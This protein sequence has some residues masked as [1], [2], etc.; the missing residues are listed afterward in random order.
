MKQD[1]V[2]VSTTKFL[3]RNIAKIISMGEIQA[4]RT[5]SKDR[6]TFWYVVAAQTKV[7]LSYKHPSHL[8]QD[9]NI[10]FPFW[11]LHSARKIRTQAT[12]IS[13]ITLRHLYGNWSSSKVERALRIWNC[14]CSD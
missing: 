9:A 4:K 2:L 10:I 12:V 13:L 5:A 7:S 14:Y 8:D 1:D 3:G 6:L 11:R